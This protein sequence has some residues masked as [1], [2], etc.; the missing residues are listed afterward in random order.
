MVRKVTTLPNV[1]FDF[2][3]MFFRKMEEGAEMEY[4]EGTAVA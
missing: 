4:S 3:K 2:T 1:D